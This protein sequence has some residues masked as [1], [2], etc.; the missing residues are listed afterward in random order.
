MP[1]SAAAPREVARLLTAPQLESLTFQRPTQF[2]EGESNFS[3][4]IAVQRFELHQVGVALAL[5]IDFAN[6]GS[7]KCVLR[8]VFE[9]A[10]AESEEQLEE[11]LR[12][13][14]T[15][16]AP[17]VIYPYAR[18]I[19]SSVVARAGGS[20]LVLPVV[21]FQR[22]FDPSTTEIPKWSPSR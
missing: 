15:Q 6:N 22:V 19:V 5:D 9:V 18:E 2:P 14:A 17:F 16:V 10:P 21:N 11:S 4:G 20:P 13:A 8:A 7:L 1:E 12:L 3:I